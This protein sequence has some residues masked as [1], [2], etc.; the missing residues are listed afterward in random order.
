LTVFGVF[1]AISWSGLLVAYALEI[2]PYRLRAKGLVIMNITVQAVLAV[3][4]QTNPV[5]WKNLPRHWNFTLFYTLWIIC[6]LVWVFFVYPETNFGGTLEEIAKI[7]DGESHVSEVES[8]E[9]RTVLDEKAQVVVEHV[10][11]RRSS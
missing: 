7:F 3:G 2:L 4:N 5:A 10:E 11:S 1:Y 6:E 9:G 8:S